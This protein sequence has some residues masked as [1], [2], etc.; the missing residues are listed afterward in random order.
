MYLLRIYLPTLLSTFKF[1]RKEYNLK[2]YIL[3]VCLNLLDTLALEIGIHHH[4]YP[5]FITCPVNKS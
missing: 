3:N 5:G 1:I 4:H 2:F